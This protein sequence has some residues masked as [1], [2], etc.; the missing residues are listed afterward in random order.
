MN[1]CLYAITYSH[2]AYNVSCE[3]NGY[4]NKAVSIVGIAQE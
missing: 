2:Q 1:I 4:T 3:N